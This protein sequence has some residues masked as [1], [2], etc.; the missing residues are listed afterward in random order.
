MNNDDI[1]THVRYLRESWSNIIDD[2]QRAYLS[3]KLHGFTYRQ[4]TAAS[5]RCIKGDKFC[6]EVLC[7]VCGLDEI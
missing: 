7:K 2:L 4:L 1:T 5:R 3:R 6:S